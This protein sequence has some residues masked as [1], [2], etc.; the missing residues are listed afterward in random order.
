MTAN[1][2]QNDTK[3]MEYLRINLSC[4]MSSKVVNITTGRWG[5]SKFGRSVE[6]TVLDKKVDWIRHPVGLGEMCTMFFK[7]CSKATTL[8]WVKRYFDANF[9]T[10]WLGVNVGGDTMYFGCE[11]DVVKYINSVM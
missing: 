9:K 1:N 4:S 3:I 2:K 10:P 11:Q 8:A 7:S 5:D 6:D